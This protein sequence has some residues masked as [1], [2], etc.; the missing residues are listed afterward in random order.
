[1]GDDVCWVGNEGGLGC[2]MEWSVMVLMFNFYLGFD[3]V[4]KRL[5][6]NVM[7]KDLGSCELVFKVLDLF[8]YFFEVD[9]FI[10][11]GWFYYVEQDN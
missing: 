9:V 7:F 8:W 11:L 6:I 5:G 10:C 1:M 2:I 4:Y 3:E